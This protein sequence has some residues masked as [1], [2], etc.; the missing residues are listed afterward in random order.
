MIMVIGPGG[1]RGSA[2]RRAVAGAAE[3]VRRALAAALPAGTPGRSEEEPH[4][5]VPAPPSDAAGA[6]G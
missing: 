1:G 3:R 6:V 2:R 4:L 5:I